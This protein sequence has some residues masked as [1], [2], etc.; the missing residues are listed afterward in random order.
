MRFPASLVRSWQDIQRNFDFLSAR[1]VSSLG[2]EVK[3]SELRSTGVI[4]MPVGASV[5]ALN[6]SGMTTVTGFIV[7]AFTGLSHNSWTWYPRAADVAL[8]NSGA[9]QNVNMFYYVIGT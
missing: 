5:P 9:A 6:L 1:G 8:I 2:K 4:A 7:V 3:L